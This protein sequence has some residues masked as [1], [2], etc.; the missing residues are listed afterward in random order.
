MQLPEPLRRAIDELTSAVP[1]GDLARA[2]DQ[3]SASYRAG[4]FRAPLDSPAARTAYLAVRLPATFAANAHVFTR[5][6]E[7]APELEIHS[8]L[9]LG[10]GPGTAT[11]AACDAF[12]AIERITLVERDAQLI[13]LGERLASSAPFAALRSAS[14]ISADLERLPALEPH[15]LVVFSYA[16][17]E[18]GAR[19]VPPLLAT[20]WNL[21]ARL[22]VIVEPGTPKNFARVLDARSWLISNGASLA[23]PCPHHL[24]CPL[25]SAGDWCHFA[26]RVERTSLHRRAKSGALGHEDEKFSYLAASREAITLPAARIVR[27]PQVRPGHVQ[28]TLCTADGL[29]RPTIGRSRKDAF[30]AAR[31]AA[32]GDTWQLS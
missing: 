16:L 17:G 22:L 4:D 18:L 23:A 10:A 8:V 19:A 7:V 14:W 5:I 24:A 11:W 31:R 15:D 1:V 6:R 21:A 29:Q 25:A 3:L 13:A 12:P 30:R 28:L 20:A 27:H 32:W 9:D 2:S 26:E